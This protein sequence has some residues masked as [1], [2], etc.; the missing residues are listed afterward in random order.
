L[1]EDHDPFYAAECLTCHLECGGGPSTT[2]TTQIFFHY[3]NTCEQCHTSTDLHAGLGHTN[4]AECHNGAPQVGNVEPGNCIVCHPLVGQG[5]CNLI[6]GHD[7]AFGAECLICHPE[8]GGGP[9]TTTTT[10]LFPH[11]TNTCEQCHAV[12]D[13][14]AG[15]GHG[16]CTECHNGPPQPGNVE[17]ANCIVCHPLAGAG[18]CNLIEGHD[19]FYAAECLTCHVECAGGPSTTTTTQSFSHY[20]VTCEECHTPTVLHA[21][22]G[23][24]NCAAC[25]NGPPQV[26]NVEP[27]NCIVCHPLVGQGSCNLIEGHDPAFGAECL[28]CHVECGGGPPTT[29]TTQSFK[30]Y[31]FYCQ[32]CHISTDL[33]AGLGHTNCAV[34]HNGPPQVANVEPSNCMVCHPLTDPGECPLVHLHVFNVP[35]S[36]A[37]LGCHAHAD[38]RTTSTTT[39]IISTTTTTSPTTT[40]TTTSSPTT[41]TTSVSTTTTVPAT[42]SDNDGIPDDMDNCPETPNPGQEDIMPPGGNGIGDACECEGN[43]DCDED[44][45]GTDAATFKAD[46]G[47]SPFREPCESGNPCHGDFDCDNDSD[48]TDAATFK[49]DFGRSFFGN[50]C[51][52]CTVKEWCSY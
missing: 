29:T 9:S 32:E 41:S 16:N 36:S 24:G 52:T 46:F 49:A 37:C 3:T 34:C 12:T 18:S 31:S 10:Q 7:P 30:H 6:E 2:T 21:G 45:D 40:T 5:S 35:G 17:P 25:H 14:H 27:G 4:C 8:C 33:H 26:G 15:L 50:P 48:G 42:D 13:L 28:T 23:H 19:P 1:V 47:R 38:C 11:Y 44:C 22:L 39:S 43:F 51:P 20:T